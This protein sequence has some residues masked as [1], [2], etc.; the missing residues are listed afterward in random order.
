[1]LRK[2]L[3]I[4]VVAA[5][6]A[7]PAGAWALELQIRGVEIRVTPA[8]F[9]GGVFQAGTGIGSFYTEVPHS[10]PITSGASICPSGAP[11]GVYLLSTSL[12]TFAGRYLGGTISPPSQIPDSDGCPDDEFA[13]TASLTSGGSASATLHHFNRF[14]FFGCPTVAASIQGTILN[15]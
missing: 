11:C 5:T 7:F 13:I 15:P 6:L 2:L 9:V 8:T 3:V 12:G 4:F 14:P 10:S 1:M